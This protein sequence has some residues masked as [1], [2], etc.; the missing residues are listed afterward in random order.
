LYG[1]LVVDG[2]NA[3]ETFCGARA[4]WS[5]VAEFLLAAWSIGSVLIAMHFRYYGMIPFQ[6]LFVAGYLSVGIYSVRYLWAAPRGRRLTEATA[7]TVPPAARLARR[8]GSVT[9]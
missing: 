3:F 8:W 1:D 7:P 4:S 5:V 2:A 9:S 6:M